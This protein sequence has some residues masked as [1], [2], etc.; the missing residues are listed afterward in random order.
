MAPRRPSTGT[1]APRMAAERSHSSDS[2]ERHAAAS[3][4]AAAAVPP[5]ICSSAASCANADER[6]VCNRSKR[7]QQLQ[8]DPDT[9]SN[10]SS[11]RNW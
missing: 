3:C 6:A 10:E 8:A 1:A 5:G 9:D 4:P 2:A 7:S 11:T